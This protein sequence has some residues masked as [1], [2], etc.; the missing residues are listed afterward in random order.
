MSYVVPF[1][2]VPFSYKLNSDCKS[3]ICIKML[4][5]TGNRHQRNLR[6]L[7]LMILTGEK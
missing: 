6:G 5:M 4:M 2:A 7:F 3:N 1:L